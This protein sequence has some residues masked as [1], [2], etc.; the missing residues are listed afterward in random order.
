MSYQV[1]ITVL[2]GLP[3]TVTYRVER[4]DP[5]V[6]IFESYLE[7]WW[8]THIHGRRCKKPPEW[9][10]ERIRK[11]KGGDDLVVEAIWDGH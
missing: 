8:I 9:L 2:G 7:E 10:Y 6:G 1:D 4:P 11:S 5:D 3:V